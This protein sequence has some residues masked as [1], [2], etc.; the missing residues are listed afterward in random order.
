M[1]R[2]QSRVQGVTPELLKSYQDVSSS[3]IGHLTD[4]GFLKGLKPLYRPIRF[5]G[6]AVT[7]RIPHLDSTAV[8]KALELARPGDV[9]V[10]DMSGDVERSC[11]GGIVSYAAQVKGIAGV[12]IE[13]CVNDFSEIAEMRF[14]VYSLGVSPLTTRILGIE[15]EVNTAIS[16][17]GVSV[18]PGD[19]VLAD[20][21]GVVVL[22]PELAADYGQVAM[23]KQS[24]ET[25]V[26]RKLDQGIPLA[27]ISKAHTF[28]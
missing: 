24:K 21:D 5:V 12:V 14:P 6:N 19:L 10:I 26:K 9:L 27:A 1:F 16:M 11:W 23:E 28:F 13:G 3:T 18:N 22:N 2:I 8:H 20:D 7:V 17:C 4:F 25:T 15:G